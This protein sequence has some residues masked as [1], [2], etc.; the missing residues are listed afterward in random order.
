M[1]ILPG[2]AASHIRTGLEGQ[3]MRF[4]IQTARTTLLLWL[5]FAAA[6]CGTHESPHVAYRAAFDKSMAVD[7]ERYLRE[8]GA[9]WDLVV[10]E[11]SKSVTGSDDVF[12][13]FMYCNDRSFERNR[14][15]VIAGNHDFGT[16]D[17]P[18]RSI[19]S[20]AFFD[21]GDMPV[22]ALDRL[23]FEIKH[24]LEDQFGLEFCRLNPARSVCD[25]EYR[26]LEETREA[27]LGA[28]GRK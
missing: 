23:A 1:G 11:Q 22:E 8:V 20:L 4:A 16:D 27:R 28:T 18:D 10:H 6:S 25:E 3:E 21:K 2:N 24:T 5:G 7:V 15:T 17:D 26:K 9:Q 13:T 14:W 19:I 12:T